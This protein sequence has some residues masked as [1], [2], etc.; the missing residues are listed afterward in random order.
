M[1]NKNS[2]LRYIVLDAMGVMYQSGDDVA[3]L[4]IPFVR[5]H[6]PEVSDAIVQHAYLLASLGEV[7]ASEFW[8]QVG[9]KH[10]LEDDYLNGHQLMPGLEAF[11]GWAADMGLRTVCLSNDVSIWS[12][13]LRDRFDLSRRLE[14]WVI[15]ADVGIRKPDA[16]IYQ[17]VLRQL[18]ASPAELLFVDDRLPNVEAA[19]HLGIRAIRFSGNSERPNDQ[20]VCWGF[21]RLKRCIEQDDLECRNGTG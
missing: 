21:D 18:G 19:R 10:T 2:G 6:N 11:L 13:K 12:R 14:K 15:S 3:E 5:Q 17:E 20:T 1:E 4:L 9:V 16:G 7:N 8:R